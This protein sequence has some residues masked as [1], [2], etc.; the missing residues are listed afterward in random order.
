MKW[1]N[2]NRFPFLH[3][4]HVKGILGAAILTIT[5]CLW[6]SA[7]VEREQVNIVPRTTSLAAV[8]S[9]S[10]VLSNVDLVL[11][12]VTVLDRANR[13][14]TGLQRADFAV[15][16]DNKPQSVRYISNVDEPASLVV[17]FDASASM[18]GKIEAER[19]AVKELINSSNPQDEFSLIVVNDKPHLLFGFNDS[20][21]DLQ[22]AVA[23]IQPTGFTALWDGIYLGVQEVRFSHNRRKAMIVISDGSDNP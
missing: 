17:V 3:C 11:L 2:S 16:D 20:V 10:V 14:V 22:A 19:N 18:A 1:A 21:T 9:A 8:S 13:A 15:L 7:Q 4:V 12:N 23:S 5:A 6:A